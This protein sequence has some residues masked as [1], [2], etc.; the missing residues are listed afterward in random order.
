M[1]LLERY[2]TNG[3]SVKYESAI[4]YLC[5]KG[6]WLCLKS[7]LALS[8]SLLANTSNLFS[9]LK[10]KHCIVYNEAVDAMEF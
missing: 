10:S 9:H 1:G 6:C 8:K 4:C 3:R 7:L 5:L 2:C